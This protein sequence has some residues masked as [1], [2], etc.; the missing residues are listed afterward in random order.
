MLDF[1]PKRKCVGRKLRLLVGL[2]RI[3]PRVVCFHLNA[4]RVKSKNAL[5]YSFFSYFLGVV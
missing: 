3:V 2:E 5:V 4:V 1:K